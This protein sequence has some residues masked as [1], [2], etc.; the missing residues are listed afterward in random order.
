LSWTKPPGRVSKA[1]NEPVHFGLSELLDV[2][3]TG[4]LR[5][6]IRRRQTPIIL[7][8]AHGNLAMWLIRVF[9]EGLFSR[10]SATRG[11]GYVSTTKRERPWR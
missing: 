1:I 10:R 9:A 3:Y 7:S 4:C 5:L 2:E 6:L 11:I 8:I